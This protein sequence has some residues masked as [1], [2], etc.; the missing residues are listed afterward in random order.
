MKWSTVFKKKEE[1]EPIRNIMAAVVFGEKDISKLL[2]FT[3]ENAGSGKPKN[4]ARK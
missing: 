2:P 1:V 4:K 3:D